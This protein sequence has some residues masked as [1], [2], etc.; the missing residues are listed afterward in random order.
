[1]GT[2]LT[3]VLSQFTSECCRESHC[4]PGHH[5]FAILRGWALGMGMLDNGEQQETLPLGNCFS[6]ESALRPH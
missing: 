3:Q 4:R 5:V 2:G 6:E 1:M